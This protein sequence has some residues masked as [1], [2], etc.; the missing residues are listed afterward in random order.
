MKPTIAVI[1]PCYNAEAFIAD[2]IQSVRSA[3]TFDAFTIEHIIVDDG[4]TDK[5]WSVISDLTYPGLIALHNEKNKGAGAARNAGIAQT[6]AEYLYCLDA[7]DALFQASLLYL[8]RAAQS[9]NHEWVY[10]DFIRGNKELRYDVGNDYYG[11]R[12]DT[13]EDTLTA[14]FSGGHF[15][16]HSSL[17]TRKL[18]TTV[19]GYDETLKYA[20]DFDLFTRFLLNGNIPHH[21]PAPLFINR[22]HDKNISYHH[23]TNNDAHKIDV[24]RLFAKYEQQL[25][26]RLSPAQ[27]TAVHSWLQ[28]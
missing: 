6:N 21:L 11:W 1:T 10:G 9:H 28:N 12:F 22:F 19:G 24:R 7:D 14:M 13:A 8:L 25:S 18:Y 17:F 4:S 20:E 23:R 3:I 16:Q 15:F 27:L 5:S 26:Q 2:C